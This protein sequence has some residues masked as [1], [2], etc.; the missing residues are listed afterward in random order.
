MLIH[1]FETAYLFSH[2]LGED[3]EM[4]IYTRRRSDIAVRTLV[5]E[6]LGDPPRFVA[7]SGIQTG[8][9][10]FLSATSIAIDGR[11]IFLEP[12]EEFR[13]NLRADVFPRTV[14]GGCIQFLFEFCLSGR[15]KFEEE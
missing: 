8:S 15:I 4:V 9:P 5:N 1:R 14:L 3:E 6:M 13:S 12:G 2:S 7:K 11:N 10:G